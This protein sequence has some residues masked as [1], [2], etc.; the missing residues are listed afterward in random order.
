MNR[1]TTLAKNHEEARNWVHV[2]ASDKSWAAS[3]C[4][5]PPC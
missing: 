5:S 1:Q 4:R 2:D 3:R